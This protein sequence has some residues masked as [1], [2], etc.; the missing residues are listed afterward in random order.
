MAKH[1]SKVRRRGSG[2][3][4]VQAQQGLVAPAQESRRSSVAN[5]PGASSPASTAHREQG[6]THDSARLIMGDLKKI[7]VVSGSIFVVLMVLFLVLPH[8]LD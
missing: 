6:I 7:G 1:Q 5:L 2:K 8:L 4:R 3:Q